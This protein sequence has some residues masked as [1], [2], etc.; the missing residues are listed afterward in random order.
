MYTRLQ[1]QFRQRP[2]VLHAFARAGEGVEKGVDPGTPR[3]LPDSQE[4]GARISSLNDLKQRQ[5]ARHGHGQRIGRAQK[6][7]ALPQQDRIAEIVTHLPNVLAEFVGRLDAKGLMV[8]IA[9]GAGVKGTAH[10]G[11][12]H[13]RQI[14]I[15]RQNADRFVDF[16]KARRIRSGRDAVKVRGALDHLQQIVER[17]RLIGRGDPF[18]IG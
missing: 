4:A 16:R 3:P 17:R 18:P 1:A 13:Q 9:E 14:L 7:R 5:Q 6:D 8:K 2:I 10:G 12:Q 15:G 11:L